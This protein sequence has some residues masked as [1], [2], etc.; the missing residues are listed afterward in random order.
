MRNL[1]YIVCQRATARGVVGAYSCVGVGG[2]PSQYDLRSPK[3]ARP[4]MAS[5]H[6]VLMPQ[7]YLHLQS[8]PGLSR[9]QRFRKLPG[10][11]ANQHRLAD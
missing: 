7:A 5:E 2:S 8:D 9:S 10:A 11:C 4:I 3:S 6:G 1:H